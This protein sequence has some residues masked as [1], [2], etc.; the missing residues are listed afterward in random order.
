MK[1][2]SKEVY[3]PNKANKFPP[4][5]YPNIFS[6]ISKNIHKK[7]CIDS[8]SSCCLSPFSYNRIPETGQIYIVNKF[9]S[10]SCKG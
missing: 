2:L 10:Y 6:P 4:S 8:C 9:I 7:I 1:K 5:P 3:L